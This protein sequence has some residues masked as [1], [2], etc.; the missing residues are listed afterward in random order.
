[1]DKEK[2]ILFLRK[3]RAVFRRNKDNSLKVICPCCGWEGKQFLERRNRKNSQCLGCGSLSRH[4]W[5]YLEL[6]KIFDKK[7][8]P[9]NPYIL[10]VAPEKSIR[11][12]LE[13]KTQG[14]NYI[15]IDNIPGKAWLNADLTN[16][17]GF[18]NNYFDLV[19]V[20]HVLEHIEDEKNAIKEIYRVLKRGGLALI[21]SPINYQRKKTRE[22]TEDEM[23]LHSDQHV[24]EYGRDFFSLLRKN[25]FKVKIV[26]SVTYSE[27][28]RETYRIGSASDIAAL[29][30]K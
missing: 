23:L 5:L 12:L 19:F 22:F 10:H 11:N 7:M 2:F 27:T 24:R 30:R 17:K 8:L 28:V 6:E 15:S 13:K 29:C 16:L 14:K 3:I 4:R 1:M 21:C 20:S 9:T 26:R 25:K 18:S